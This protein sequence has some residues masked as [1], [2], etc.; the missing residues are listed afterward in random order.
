MPITR[1]CDFEGCGYTT[2][3]SS[4][5]NKHKLTHTGEKTHKCDQCDY[6]ATSKYHLDRHKLSHNKVLNILC[7]EEGCNY[8][9]NLID[10]MRVHMLT[11]TGEKPHEC[12]ECEF[13]T[14]TASKLTIH[15]RTH[16]GEKPFKCLVNGCEA[17]FSRNDK[18]AV[19]MN[20]HTGE[21]PYKCEVEGCDKAYAKSEQ[22]SIHRDS[23]TG[24][25]RYECEFENCLY[26]TSD[27]SHFAV[28]KRRHTG[29]KKYFCK[30]DDCDA[31]FADSSN[32]NCHK[33]IHDPEYQQKQKKKEQKVA[34][35]LTKNGIVFNREHTVNL[36]ECI[37]TKEGKFCKIDFTMLTKDNCLIAIECDENQH[38]GYPV[39]CEIRRMNDIYTSLLTGTPPLKGIHWIRYNPDKFKIDDKE[40][41]YEG[42][43]RLNKLKETI[44]KIQNYPPKN[45]FTITY[46]F[47]DIFNNKP[48]I[49]I[50]K[51][52]I[53]TFKEHVYC[54]PIKN[55]IVYGREG[56]KPVEEMEKQLTGKKGKEPAENKL[57][58]PFEDCDYPAP[59]QSVLDT[60]IKSVHTKVKDVI[61]AECGLPCLDI[62]HLNAHVK[63]VHDKIRD[64]KCPHCSNKFGKKSGLNRHI[65]Q[66]HN[67]V[68]YTCEKCGKK[69]S[70]E[71]RLKGHLEK[72]E[73][74][75]KFPC[76]KCENSYKLQSSLNRHVQKDHKE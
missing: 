52:F 27:W 37:K 16:T 17:E 51:D 44:E 23:H 39:S 66:V 72:C 18:L 59:C 53:D 47:Y 58:C 26:A 7:K 15:K 4:H 68:K 25:K 63:L 19:H 50:D 74:K 22:L 49:I 42:I 65:K 67:K 3:N 11:H 30:I 6:G 60:H 46:L 29:E 38:K 10:N 40:S 13:K 41:S 36:G 5:F 35:F 73:G 9:T 12:D 20:T 56:K 1:T 8:K 64:H 33:K 70:S 55:E 34:I 69:L 24:R 54:Y 61:C 48:E 75:L 28:H 71:G 62:G 32:L 57:I 21:K 45:N 31:G 76:D 2:T 14:T 43:K